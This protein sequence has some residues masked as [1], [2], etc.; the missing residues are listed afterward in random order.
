MAHC[1]CH[2][3]IGCV[4]HLFCCMLSLCMGLSAMSTGPCSAWNVP[5]MIVDRHRP[6]FKQAYSEA[7]LLFVSCCPPSLYTLDTSHISLLIST[8]HDHRASPPHRATLPVSS[9]PV[10][11]LPVSLSSDIS[12]C[13]VNK[14]KNWVR[15]RIEDTE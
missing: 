7:P 6:I 8:P 5:S 1:P 3:N 4:C 11:S 10:S 15:S 12:S 13:S 14:G 9:L 2:I